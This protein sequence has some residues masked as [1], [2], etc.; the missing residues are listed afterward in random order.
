MEL[1]DD[2]INPQQNIPVNAGVYF[3]L[4]GAKVVRSP[5]QILPLYDNEGN[6]AFP[7]NIVFDIGSVAD[8]TITSNGNYTICQLA[9]QQDVQEDDERLRD[10]LQVVLSS[11]VTP[12][13]FN[14]LGSF[15]INV[16]SNVNNQSKTVN[17]NSNT[18]TL[19]SADNGYSG[20]SQ[21][22]V[23]TNV[24][25]SLEPKI[26]EFTGNTDGFEEYEPT[27]GIDGFSNV[28]V[29]VDVQPSTPSM[30]TKTITVNTV[31]EYGYSQEYDPPNG[32][33]GWNKIMVNYEI[34]VTDITVNQNGT[35]NPSDYHVEAFSSVNV[36]VPVEK[37]PILKFYYPHNSVPITSFSNNIADNLLS[38]PSHGAAVIMSID[39]INQYVE[40]EIRYNFTSSTAS[41][42]AVTGTKSYVITDNLQHQ[43]DN[44]F[45][46]DDGDGRM[47]SQF[48]I[49][50]NATSATSSASFLIWY[51]RFSRLHFHFALDNNN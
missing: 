24:E 51:M 25:P 18:Q 14:N 13:A 8:T 9:E 23:N 5:S 44:W 50:S 16:P 20:L 49:T 48:K 19:I 31:P 10:N 4:Y 38:V 37:I 22:V 33:D 45:G 46:I 3:K 41:T 39:T 26:L 30:V 7:A 40:L 11:E 28:R 27:P 47:V 2:S 36:N 32:V 43:Y 21:V 17:I 42:T 34:P 15:S 6:T 35:Y 29:K 1:V 12:Q